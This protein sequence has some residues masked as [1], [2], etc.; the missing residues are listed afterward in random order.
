[1]GLGRLAV[2][3]GGGA[4]HNV[5]RSSVLERRT[6]SGQRRAI[7]AT[8]RHITVQFLAEALLLATLG[9]LA[10]A[11]LGALVTAGYATTRGWAI[12][13]PPT[14]LAGGVAAAVVIGALAG[15]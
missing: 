6:E 7:G 4:I 8:R 14:A 5:L 10:G 9:G 3:W 15:L 12:A 2:R 13:V 1:W 11:A